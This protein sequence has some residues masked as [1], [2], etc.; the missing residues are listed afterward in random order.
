MKISLVL[1][2]DMHMDIDRAN[3]LMETHKNHEWVSN[4]KLADVIVIMTCAF[5]LKKHSSMFVIAEILQNAKPDSTIIATGCLAKLNKTELEA[6]PNLEVKSLE[7][8]SAMLAILPSS[9]SPQEV[10]TMHQNI[11]IISNGCLRKC[12]Y[13]VYSL[14]EDKYTSKPMENILSE[15]E[16]LSRTESIIYLTGAHETSDYGIDLY[17]SRSFSTLIEQACTNF[18]SIDFGIGWFNPDGLTDDVID[19]MKR[20]KNIVHIMLHLQHNDNNILRQ[21]HRT[22]FE[23]T[24]GKIKKL[25]SAIPDLKISTEVIVGFPGETDESFNGLVR[26]LEESRDIFYD[27]GVASYEPVIGT[28]AATLPNLPSP[29]I[30]QKRMEFIEKRFNA[31]AFPAPEDFKPVLS[32]YFDACQFFNN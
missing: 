21:M 14:I 30:R 23:I 11:V 17:G 7:E 32:S 29:A 27:I 20:L 8:V 9:T 22:P 3:S 26:F 15:V 1:C 18:P 28:K 31:T 6:I 12:S 25:H 13:C 5:G 2:S 19:V 16:K 4:Y 24:E 10:H